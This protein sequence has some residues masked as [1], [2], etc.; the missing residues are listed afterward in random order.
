[1]YISLFGGEKDKDLDALF[2]K[3]PL[4]WSCCSCDKDLDQFNGKLGDYKNW[5][6]FPP[7]ETIPER[8]GRVKKKY[9]LNA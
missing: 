9:F 1:V 4:P 5:A 6:V 3:R 7:K 8:M 2:V